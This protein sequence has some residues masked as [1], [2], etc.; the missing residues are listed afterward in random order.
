MRDE[1]SLRRAWA[2]AR[3]IGASWVDDDVASMG[4]A[5]SF[6]TL[7]SL[8]PLLLIVIALAG[9]VFGAD[10]ARGA[11][12]AQLQSLVGANAA[13]AV[14]QMIVDAAKPAEG[15][16]AAMLGTLL[17]LVGATTVFSE[18]QGALDR[19]WR[20]P[21]PAAKGGLFTLLRSRLLAFGLILAVGFLLI[22]SL[23]ASAAL[24]A[25]EQWWQPILGGWS[26]LV[27]TVHALGD[28]ALVATLFALIYKFM[29]RAQVQWR[30]VWV[31][32]VVTAAL[33]TLG[34]TLIGA[35][36]G[37]SGT[38]SVFGAASSLVVVLLWV[39]YSAQ[40]FLI[41][42]TFTW[43][44]TGARRD[45]EYSCLSTPDQVQRSS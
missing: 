13:L 12:D 40:I 8:A 42:A 5:L 33:F 20:V 15:L 41:G 35:Y 4:A 14:Q 39:Y 28:F 21:A 29:P 45:W 23:V 22:V 36:I 11:L 10:A 17:L 31:G 34:K 9:K 19:I 27:S 26:V 16:M 2:M 32:A 6:Y 38:A 7:F 37:R 43:V 18:L 25:L 3:Q 44:Y 24:A 1:S 30:D